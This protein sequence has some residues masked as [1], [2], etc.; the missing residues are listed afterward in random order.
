MS[1]AV[2]PISFDP[3]ASYLLDIEVLPMAVFKHR[4]NDT[5]AHTQRAL[6]YMMFVVTK[7]DLIHAV[8]SAT[9]HCHA[10]DCLLIKPNQIHQFSNSLDWDGWVLLFSPNL[11][12]SHSKE[13][14]ILYQLPTSFS[15][16]APLLNACINHL[17]TMSDDTHLNGHRT[18]V[19]TLL[20]H[21]LNAL[22]V[23]LRL[24]D[25]LFA[26]KVDADEIRAAR[27]KRFRLL[28][29]SH[30]ETE[31]QIGFYADQMGLSHKTLNRLCLQMVNASAKSLITDRLVLEAKRLLVHTTL[32]IQSI[33]DVL[34]FDE[35][36]NF[37]KL[38]KKHTQSTP[39]QF[40]IQHNSTR[41]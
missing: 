30:F 1:N 38:F 23:R 36:S 28:L 24:A 41:P 3:P 27:F 7:G 35:V 5:V 2:I 33:G 34:S 31:H 11:L 18:E 40:R 12:L 25:E 16:N 13:E 32:P 8:D 14:E 29:E 19:N 20:R 22:L 39:K 15:L 21:Q 4:L 10:H 9:H 37:V 26:F 17:R 6:F